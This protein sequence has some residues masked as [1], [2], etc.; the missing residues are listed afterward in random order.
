MPIEDGTVL[1]TSWQSSVDVDPSQS[2]SDQRLS[3]ET[4]LGVPSVAVYDMSGRQL[5]TFDNSYGGVADESG[6]VAF[7]RLLAEGLVASGPRPS[8][9]M[10]A[11][12]A[13]DTLTTW[14]PRPSQ[15]V[16]AMWL[17]GALLAYEKGEGDSLE[18]H[19]MNGPGEARSLG[20]V[21]ILAVSPTGNRL[22]V[23]GLDESGRSILQVIDSTAGALIAL[24]DPSQFAVPPHGVGLWTTDDRLIITGDN[25]LYV[26]DVELAE[27][28]RIDQVRTISAEPGQFFQAVL[29][30]DNDVITLLAYNYSEQEATAALIDCTIGTA[31]CARNSDLGSASA[32]G[33]FFRPGAVQEGS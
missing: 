31:K 3:A 19:R 30:A 23:R 12:R 29:R 2:L 20:Q 15:W 13:G 8:D 16:P 6:R 24:A 4:V 26:V 1:V 28:S 11:N 17:G 32:V 22:A 27:G 18:L 33:P 7:A 9:I 21:A 25:H 14:S 10:V 5:R